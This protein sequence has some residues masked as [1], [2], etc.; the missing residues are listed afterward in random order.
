MRA[1]FH[2]KLGTRSW[3]DQESSTCVACAIHFIDSVATLLSNAML[4]YQ[5]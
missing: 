4:H 1:I 3:T 2:K 5:S